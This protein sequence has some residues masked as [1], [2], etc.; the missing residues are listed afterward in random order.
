MKIAVLIVL[1]FLTSCITLKSPEVKGISNFTTSGLLTGSPEMKFNVDL[2]NPNSFGVDIA[3]FNVNVK[4]GNLSLADIKTSSLQSING[5]SDVSI[6]LSFKPSAE[7]LNNI[8]QSGMELLN[9]NN[10]AKFSGSGSFRVQK[11]IF[12]RTFNFRF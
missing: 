8:M 1:S 7:Q 3:D 9:Q 5:L 4:Y 12:G 6:P 11:F 10:S 2:H